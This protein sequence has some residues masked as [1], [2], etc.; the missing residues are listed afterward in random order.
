[1]ADIRKDYRLAELNEDIAGD[2]PIAFFGKWFAEAE[3]SQIEDVNAM[4]L[5]T[6]DA[7]NRPHARIV[8]L[9]GLTQDGFSFFTNYNSAKG[10]DINV[11]AHVALVFF[12]KE[13]ERQVRI[14]GIVEKLSEEESDSYF[15][16]RPKGSRIGTWA[17]PQS[18]VI[19][20]RKEL[21]DTYQN[22]EEQFSNGIIPR[23][24]NWGGYRVYPEYIEF[25]QGGGSRLH[26][27]ILFT[28]LDNKKWAKSRL[29]P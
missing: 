22:Y 13:L 19:S 5:A 4:T 24:S 2:D 6:V 27:R 29:A 9:K 23:P 10:Q 18:E 25:W 26:D 16:S 21:E 17:S 12:W 1:M 20:S 28:L 7:R 3:A 15:N 14:E 11:N 8:L